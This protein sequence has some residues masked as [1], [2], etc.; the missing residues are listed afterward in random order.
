VDGDSVPRLF[1][2]QHLRISPGVYAASPAG[3]LNVTEELGSRGL[4]FGVSIL[5]PIGNAPFLR[6]WRLE[7]SIL[8]QLLEQSL[9]NFCPG[10]YAKMIAQG[11]DLLKGFER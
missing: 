2:L 9:N 3:G 10:L 6:P 5:S 4:R 7:T 8:Q 1:Y 11:V